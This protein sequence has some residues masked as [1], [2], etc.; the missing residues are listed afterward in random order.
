MSELPFEQH[1][2]LTAAQLARQPI[3]VYPTRKEKDEPT[4][5]G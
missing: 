1:V 4:G 3:F 2:R 5:T